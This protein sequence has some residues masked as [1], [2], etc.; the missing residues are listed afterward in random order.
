MPFATLNHPSGA[1]AKICLHGAVVTSWKREDGSEILYLNPKNKW[2]G[3]LPIAGGI[4]IAWP[5]LGAGELT[6]NG[7]MRQMHWSVIE[8]EAFVE[9]DDPRPS[10]S[11]HTESSDCEIADLWPY[12]FEAVYTVSLEEPNKRNIHPRELAMMEEDLLQGKNV[13]LPPASEAPENGYPSVLRCTLE[14]L[15]KG[16][17]TM[18]FTTGIMNHFATENIREN[19]KAVKVL[20]LA[21]KYVLDYS[22]D[23][24]R[25]KL[26]IEQNDFLFFNPDSGQDVDKVFVDCDGEGQVLFCPGSRHYFDV[27]HEEGFNDVQILHP[28]GA[29]PEIACNSVCLVSAKKSVPVR[30]EPGAVWRGEVDI[31]AHNEYW[32][33]PQFEKEDPTTIP[34]PSKEEALPPK[35]DKDDGI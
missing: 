1:S 2:D 23:A 28:A 34:V 26:K 18:E 21:G 29:F 14:I 19:I 4:T 9:G 10:V 20:G 22:E 16:D 13:S 30:L 32:P 6:F 7:F 25:P 35:Q 31:S 5:Q 17:K 15:N 12:D 3:E 8:S 33:L 27:H 24:M 11:F